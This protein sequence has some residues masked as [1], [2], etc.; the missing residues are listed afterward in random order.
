MPVYNAPFRALMVAP[1][2]GAQ[3]PEGYFCSRASQCVLFGLLTNMMTCTHR[4]DSNPHDG[5]D[6]DNQERGG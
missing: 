4:R 2:I 3:L 5:F 6:T 1:H